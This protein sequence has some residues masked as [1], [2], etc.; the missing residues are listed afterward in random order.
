[1]LL[2]GAAPSAT[3]S[4]AADVAAGIALF[5]ASSSLCEPVD[6]IIELIAARAAHGRGTAWL[7]PLWHGPVLDTPF[8]GRGGS[9][10]S[11]ILAVWAELPCGGAR[12]LRGDHRRP[13]RWQWILEINCRSG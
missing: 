3:G 13:V 1:M 11:D 12:L 6:R 9:A 2:T 8:R 4:D 10:R 5:M 7:C